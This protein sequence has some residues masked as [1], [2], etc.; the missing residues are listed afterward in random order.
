MKK[1]LNILFILVSIGCFSQTNKLENRVDSVEKAFIIYN[2]GIDVYEQ[3][4]FDSAIIMFSR[5]I[6]L[7][8]EFAD[9]YNNRGVTRKRN[10]DFFG[11]IRDYDFAIQLDPSISIVYNNKA[12]AE[13]IMGDLLQ[14]VI[15]LKLS[16]LIL[17]ISK[18]ATI[19]V[20]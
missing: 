14:E 19:R 8:P 12:S 4:N 9:A 17:P 6:D 3:N 11:A 5:A 18:H 15:I 1:L 10:G 7:Y 2:L 20:Q 16:K 13:R